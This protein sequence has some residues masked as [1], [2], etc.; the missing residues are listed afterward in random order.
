MTTSHEALYGVGDGVVKAVGPDRLG[1]VEKAWPPGSRVLRGGLVHERAQYL[2]NWGGVT[3]YEDEQHIVGV[4]VYDNGGRSFD[5]YT[6]FMPGGYV[7]GIGD[8]G[9]VPNGFCMTV[10]AV[11][12]PHLGERITLSEMTDAARKAVESELLLAASW[13]EE[14]A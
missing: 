2:V 3:C 1:I 5:R 13:K 4:R 9:N 8:T 6:C 14:Q 7:L 11:E 10:D 12:G